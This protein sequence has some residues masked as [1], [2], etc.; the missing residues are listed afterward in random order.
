MAMLTMRARRFLNNT[1]R[2]LNLYGNETVAFDKTKVKYY[3]C[4]KRGHFARECRAPRA[5]DKR[6]REITRRNMLVETTNSSALV[7]Y[8]GLRGYDWSVQAE[9]RPNYTLMAYSTSSSDSEVSTD[10]NC[11]RTCLKTVETLKF[12]N[13]QLLKYLRIPKIQT[14]TYKTCLESVEARLLVYKKNESIYKEDIK[15]LKHEIYLKD[16]A[17]TE[18]K[19][20][21]ELTQKQKN[22]IK[23][24]VENFEN[25]SK[26]LSEL[27]ASQMADKCK[28]G[29]GYNAVPP[30]YTGNFLPL[31]PDLPGL[32]EFVNESI[33][34]E[35][36]VKK[37]E[38][39]TNDAKA[40]AD[41]PKVVKK[42]FSPPLI[43][44]WISNSK[45]KA[46]SNLRLRR[47]LLN[48]VLLK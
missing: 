42:S 20:K 45:D 32:Q 17:I 34:S 3:N 40:S 6:N 26:S 12:Q 33:V 47:K 46:E 23:L 36:I 21:L 41:K 31:K 11:S 29:L 19:R 48:L 22:E 24:S 9:E 18:L 4:H 13:E 25:S 10:S 27:L 38:I 5:Q 7:S 1:G 2:K 30:P 8:D 28:A 37:L 16:I 35:P 43:K 14:I 15:L 44:D 39:K